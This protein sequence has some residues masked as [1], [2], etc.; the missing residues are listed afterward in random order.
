M[1]EAPPKPPRGKRASPDLLRL[2]DRVEEML[3][4]KL[5][6]KRQQQR[7]ELRKK[8]QA[9][10]YEPPDDLPSDVPWQIEDMQNIL[11]EVEGRDASE[12][13]ANAV[14]YSSTAD[15]DDAIAVL[16]ASTAELEPETR[17]YIANRWG[18][19]QAA[20]KRQFYKNRG[21]AAAILRLKAL[22]RDQGLSAGQADDLIAEMLGF[23]SAETLRKRLQ[24]ARH[25]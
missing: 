16:L 18:R 22:L 1:K 3:C 17:H 24:R 12:D 10:F 13:D 9:C 23:S 20:S 8:I 14:L 7:E 15:E 21:F 5:P 2:R 25:E 4:A 19:E 11:E 6:W